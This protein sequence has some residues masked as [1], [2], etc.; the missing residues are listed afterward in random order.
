[1]RRIDPSQPG[2]CP[3]PPKRA[4]CLEER[5]LVLGVLV[6]HG[7]EL[8]V[9]AVGGGRGGGRWAEWHVCRS[10]RV[11]S[12]RNKEGQVWGKSNRAG[13][14]NC[15]IARGSVTRLGRQ[16]PGLRTHERTQA[17]KHAQAHQTRAMSVGSIISAL[18]GSS[19]CTGPFQRFFRLQEFIESRAKTW[20]HRNGTG[21]HTQTS[22]QVRRTALWASPATRTPCPSAQPTPP[23]CTTCSR[24]AP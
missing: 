19:Y 24:S 3:L 11:R 2:A 10:A 8:A 16:R 14:I 21:K 22:G 15:A 9:P 20:S 7:L 4:A 13:A 18:V 5:L 17:R 12:L 6:H 23:P 1:M